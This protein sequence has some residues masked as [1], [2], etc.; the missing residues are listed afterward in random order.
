V[1]GWR[2]TVH[3]H[4]INPSEVEWKYFCLSAGRIYVPGGE[5]HE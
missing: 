2:K 1:F 4:F 3:Y 5:W